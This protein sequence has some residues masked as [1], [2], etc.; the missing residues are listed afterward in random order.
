M[1]LVYRAVLQDSDGAIV[2]AVEPL[3]RQWLLDKKLVNDDFD[4]VPEVNAAL[5]LAADPTWLQHQHLPSRTKG[6]PGLRR[7]RL[8]EESPEDRWVT[9]VVWRAAVPTQESLPLDVGRAA[10]QLTL[11]DD[12]RGS[13]SWV[14]VDL[15]HEPMGGRP[16]VRPGSPRIVRNLMAAGEAHDGTLPLTAEPFSIRARHVAELASFI[17]DEQRHAPVVVFAHDAKRAYDQAQLS[18]L[19][20]RDLAGVAAV[21]VLADA[22]A[23]QALAD[24]LPPEYAV[25]AGAIRTYLPGAAGDG[26]SPNRHRVL[27]RVSLAALGPRAFPALKDQVLQ[28]STRRPAP[29]DIFLLRRQVAAPPTPPPLQPQPEPA[30]PA[31]DTA[32]QWLSQQVRRIRSAL[33]RRPDEPSFSD[34]ATAQEALA[35]EVGHI[36]ERA[37]AQPSLPAKVEPDEGEQRLADQ[38]DEVQQDRKLLQDLLGQ[39]S[40]ELQT[41][42]T[43]LSEIRESFSGLRDDHEL[44]ELELADVLRSNDKLRR[45]ANWLQRRLPVADQHVEDED[46]VEAPEF[47]AEVIELAR[48]RLKHVVIGPTDQEAAE[49]DVHA[50]ASLC[51]AK[52]WDALLALEAFAAARS[53]G[54]FAGGFR[55]WCLQPDDGHAVSAQA[56]AMGESETVDSNPDLRAK[57]VF[58]VPRDVVPDGQ[59]YMAAHIKLLKRGD[60]APRLHFHDDS[61][62]ATGKVYVGYIGR[63]LPTARFG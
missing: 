20:A 32:L 18:R 58:P 51:A 53:S 9:S 4:I 47:V 49:L 29:V 6:Q 36:L 27:G 2:N 8:V 41:V 40:D 28:L 39:A 17:R 15:E 5:P 22:Q 10:E 30:L 46:D 25:Y 57:R 33:G 37:L 26:D 35:T 16:V 13:G 19:L 12:P 62:G 63:H 60:V 56:V 38:L 44:L 45:R 61:G 1:P 31:S 24:A 21:F 3:F 11:A 14:W 52:A 50:S 42:H 7:L 55:Q 34:V 43:S 48:T 59:A 54:A 23:T